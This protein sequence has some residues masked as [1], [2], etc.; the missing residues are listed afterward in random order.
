[1]WTRG[2]N[3]PNLE[4]RLHVQGIKKDLFFFFVYDKSIRT[5]NKKAKKKIK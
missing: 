2:K 3:I 4:N 5:V 1:M